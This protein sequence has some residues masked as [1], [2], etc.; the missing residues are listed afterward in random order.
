MGERPHQ[1]Y[2]CV[3]GLPGAG[4]GTQVDKL[5]EQFS[6]VLHISTGQLLRGFV[7]ATRDLTDEKGR[8]VAA[9]IENCMATGDLVPD[10]VIIH[11]LEDCVEAA[12]EDAVLLLDGFP[13]D[14]SQARE[15]V[16]LL[17]GPP[18]LSVMFEVGEEEMTRRI[19]ARN[20]GRADDNMEA[21]SHRLASFKQETMP[22]V[23]HLEATRFGGVEWVNGERGI[24]EIYKDFAALYRTRSE[25]LARANG[26][27]VKVLNPLKDVSGSDDDDE[28]EDAITASEKKP[29]TM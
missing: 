27:I 1:R 16:K 6:E 5:C 10:D 22:A 24:D 21:L 7:E 4:K 25:A 23:D 13:R 17:G 29:N 9:D 19:L 15:L 3:F 11:V 26:E 28:D 2:V 8:A 14:L 18:M 12:P 20:E